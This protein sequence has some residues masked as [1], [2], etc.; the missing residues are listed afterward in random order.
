MLN[1]SQIQQVAIRRCVDEER[2]LDQRIP[3]RFE[4]SHSDA[5]NPITVR[6]RGERSMR[7]HDE[8]SPIELVRDHH[9]VQ[10]GD[11]D[12]RVVT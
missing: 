10:H 4:A 11:R 7:V 8:Q 6:A 5:G 3:P 2:R 9:L 1:P 12:S